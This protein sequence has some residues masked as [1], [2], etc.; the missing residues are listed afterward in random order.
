[1]SLDIAGG[2]EVSEVARGGA[3]AHMVKDAVE[4]A[5]PVWGIGRGLPGNVGDGEGLEGLAAVGPAAQPGG[6][7]NGEV[8]ARLDGRGG[9]GDDR[10]NEREGG[11]EAEVGAHRCGESAGLKISRE[12][13]PRPMEDADRK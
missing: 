10:R 8:K 2:E 7:F 3:A 12:R 6:A 5:E 9:I 1:M 4:A 13:A 11:D